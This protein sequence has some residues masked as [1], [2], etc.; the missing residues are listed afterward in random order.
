MEEWGGVIEEE[1]L[2]VG[3]GGRALMMFGRPLTQ[4][5][6]VDWVIAGL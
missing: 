5:E 4:P 1:I 3:T 2:H 6:F